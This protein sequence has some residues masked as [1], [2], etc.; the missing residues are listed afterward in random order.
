MLTQGLLKKIGFT[1]EQI[2]EYNK[3]DA[4]YGEEA[5]KY[6]AMF[7]VDKAD[8]KE[9]LEKLHNHIGNAVHTYTLDLIF[10]LHCSEFLRLEYLK[11]NINEE[12][13]YNAMNDITYKL[14]EC[15]SVKKVF[16]H[17][18]VANW[19]YGFFVLKR[20]ALGRLQYDI[21]EFPEEDITILGKVIKKGSF[22]LGC[23]IPSSGRLT[24]ELC[25]DSYKK[26]YE[27]FKDR[28]GDDGI[29]VIRC[30]SWLLYEPYLNVF[31]A[32]SNTGLFMRNFKVYSNLER[33]SFQNGWRLFG[34]DCPADVD[35]DTLPSDTT[36]RR[37]FIDYMKKGGSHGVGIGAIL[38][39]GEKILTNH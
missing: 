39:D 13:F 25:L 14:R 3:Y 21:L 26:A 16:G 20:F 5:E 29:L 34:V 15:L 36:M 4:I 17:S 18:N 28:L 11:N 24:Q 33:E 7:M 6:A 2:L 8:Y 22:V 31:G 19:Y 32:T 27:F 35:P 1:D 12:L 30:A 23:H 9:T 10:V 37:S 38:F